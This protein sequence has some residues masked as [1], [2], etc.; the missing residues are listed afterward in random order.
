MPTKC[1][2]V[3]IVGA[4][5]MSA[6]ASQKEKAAVASPSGSLSALPAY[7]PRIDRHPQAVLFGRGAL[8]TLRRVEASLEQ[9]GGI[10]LRGYDLSG[11]DLRES[12]EELLLASFDSRTIWPPPD[13]IASDFD[14]RR[15]LELGK[16]PGIGVRDLHAQGVDGRGI[17]IA[18]IDQPLLVDHLEYAGQL[19]LY[20]E[21]RIA[22]D[23]PSQMHGPAVAS[24]AVGRSTGVAPEADLYYIAAWTFDRGGG[25]NNFTYNFTYYAQAVRRVLEIN[26]GL[27]SDRKIRVISMQ[28]GWNAGQKGYQEITDAVNDAKAEGLF[29]VSSSIEETYGFRFNGLGRPPLEDPNRPASY[30]P[31]LFWSSRFYLGETR[32]RDYLT[33]SLMVPMDSRTTAS[34]CGPDEYVF[35]REGG[36]SW[37]IPYIAGLYALSAQIKSSITPSEFWT[38]ALATSRD[39][40]VARGGVVLRFGRMVDPP[41]L[42][43]ALRADR[44]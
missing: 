39:A 20:E 10:D 38:S 1:F 9:I 40:S 21:I 2:A 24:I 43:S 13:R 29:V 16:E 22:S 7:L 8:S 5:V 36:W 19:R 3:L 31:G 26:A 11:V 41:A 18:I 44:S 15:I 35:Y 28:V 37:S 34:P 33:D 23:T 32:V 17:G 6:C 42:I 27:P 4:V 25:S 14:W 30:E 12:S